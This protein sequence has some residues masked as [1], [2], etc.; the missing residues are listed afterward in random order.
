MNQMAEREAARRQLMPIVALLLSLGLLAERACRAPLPVRFLVV[1]VLRPSE[2]VARDF[3]D[4]EYGL[5]TPGFAGEGYNVA[6]AAE[7]SA[8]DW[9]ATAFEGFGPDAALRLAEQFMALAIALAGFVEWLAASGRVR[10][11]LSRSI[12]LARSALIC[13]PGRARP[14]V[15]H[16]TS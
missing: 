3:L 11:G 1:A 15:S 2:A 10:I 8:T 9:P 7:A 12:C 6:P 13:S 16:D 5:L 14:I 4:A